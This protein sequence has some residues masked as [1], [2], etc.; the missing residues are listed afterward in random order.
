LIAPQAVESRILKN[1]GCSR[2]SSKT[3][4]RR[5]LKTYELEHLWDLESPMHIQAVVTVEK[6]KA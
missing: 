6:G 1:L 3:G 2:E 4:R 5:Y